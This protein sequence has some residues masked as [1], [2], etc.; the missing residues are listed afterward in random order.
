[1]GENS[2]FEMEY[3][4]GN[5]VVI[6]IKSAKLHLMPDSTKGHIKTARK[7]MLLALRD[8]V[9]SAVRREDTHTEGDKV[10]PKMRR[11][12]IVVE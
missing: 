6:R 1:M 3:N 4:P 12:K 11:K 10:E 5:E 9:D 2:L 7:E 8:L